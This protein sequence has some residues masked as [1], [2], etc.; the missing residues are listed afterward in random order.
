MRKY[1][2]TPKGDFAVQGYAG[3]SG[4]L[5]AMNVSEARRKGLLGFAI[6][7]RKPG[8]KTFNFQLSSLHFPGQS[9]TNAKYDATPS[10]KA[11]IQKFRWGLYNVDP[12]TVYE[13]RVYLIYGTPDNPKRGPCL[14]LA[15]ST[16]PVSGEHRVVFNRAV[17]ASQAFERKFVAANEMLKKKV[18]D[19]PPVS[20]WPVNEYNESPAAWLERGLLGEI[21]GIIKRAIDK[22]WALDIAI[23]EY[24]LDSIVQAVNAAQAR[25]VHVRVLY[26]A[27]KSDPQTAINETN[28]E[29]IKEKR[30]RIT[31]AICHD[32]FIVLSKVKN[33]TRVPCE[34]LC[35]STNFTE[36]GVYRQANVVHV[37]SQK[38]I[39]R[40]Y[41]NMFEV[42]WENHNHVAPARA[43]ITSNNPITTEPGIN[44][45]FSPRA[46]PK[47]NDNLLNIPGFTDLDVFARLIKEAQR[48][49]LFC[50]AFK[51]QG[52]ILSILSG[53]SNNAAILRYGLQNCKSD[54]TGYHRNNATF[55]ASAVLPG[56]VLEGWRNEG[57]KR[58]KGNILIH[59]K[60]VI[61]DFTSTD[62]TI[63]SGSHNLSENAS[64]S[65]DE[66]FLIIRG[67]TDLADCYACE[68]LRF[69]DH[70][71]FRYFMKQAK[72]KNAKR[73]FNLNLAVNSSWTDEYFGGSKQLDRELFCK[74]PST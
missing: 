3:T 38:D 48:D 34:V 60:V 55:T 21:T 4:I 56:N 54:I 66:N 73:K 18:K 26:H 24:E 23:Y 16:H 57:Q 39:A 47:T 70:Y 62:P 13:F 5:L 49:V 20:Q 45:G 71:R 31:S 43:W 1:V 52:D 53:K 58:Q 51:P 44:I 59:T 17:V 33:G 72:D 15:L 6:S 8:E 7:R 46:K 67:N 9:H 63:I 36:N 27:N 42:L 28:L 12:D 22:N 35:G 68:V 19:V 74:L 41:E 64:R 14:E 32:K 40:Q 30:P 25:G 10:D 50:T 65:N 11:P 37:I 61:I 29:K 69:Y 2:A